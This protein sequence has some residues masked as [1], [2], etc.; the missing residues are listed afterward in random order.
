MNI[1]SIENLSKQYNEKPLFKNINIG[2]SQGEKIGLVGVNGAGKSTFIKVITGEVAPES[3][4][5]AI[6][7][8]V[9]VGY[10]KQEPEFRAD[11][12]VWQAIFEHPNPV[13]EAVKKYEEALQTGEG[14]EEAMTAMTEFDAWNTEYKIKEILGK[15]G[16]HDTKAKVG[17]LSGGQKK[18]IALAQV[19]LMEPD[20]LILDEPTNHL[21]LNVIE[22][23]EQYLS[24]AN[25]SLLL[26]SHDRYFLDIVTDTIWEIDQ[27]QIFKYEGNYSYFLEARSERLS[28]QANEAEKARKMFNKELEWL[29][30]QPK[31][32]GTKAKYRI[33]AAEELRQ[34]S[35][36]TV[37][38]RKMEVSVKP[39]RQG[40]KVLELKE[41][42]KAFPDKK[43][44]TD[45]SYVFRRG[46]KIG[47][48]GDNGVG[49]S[50]FLN[51]ITGKIAPDKGIVDKGENTTFGYYTQQVI[52]MPEN[53]RVIDVVKEVAEFIELAN[54]EQVSASA[55]LTMFLFP[56]AKQYDLVAK[57]S[58]G[59]RRRLQLLR[60]LIKNPNFLILDEPTN[61]LD[62][63]TLTI[64][65]NFFSEFQ[66]CLLI[67]SH[68]RYFMDK[69]AEHL[70]IF[71]GNGEISDFNGSYSEYRLQKDLE[72]EQ[73]KVDKTKKEF[74]KKE[75]DK[76]AITT[77]NTLKNKGTDIKTKASFKEKQEFEALEKEIAALEHKK[78]E[79]V[80][81]LNGGGSHEEIAAWAKEIKN[82]DEAVEEKT[83]RWIEL[84]ELVM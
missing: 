77:A 25:L 68:D 82:I 5:V 20:F 66:G 8:G 83:L 57:L 81:K 1:I 45:F 6:R 28:N 54:G 48:V 23:L 3:G 18:R 46:E 4:T 67:V 37:E 47:I 55:L 60:V 73:K 19:L 63:F 26:V 36:N 41:V 35:L 14:L 42:F 75:N 29:R 12:T 15:L 74:D 50:T 38:D 58:G 33:N 64:L 16:I 69:L 34:K 2:I 78:N 10:L 24:T 22:W 27:E 7:N 44:I 52:Q 9:R 40:K 71:E 21:D 59:E 76:K 43:I 62:I 80:A 30:K 17:N 84:A 49:K 65:E 61:D 72:E 56:P 32:R 31:A 11:A 51:I 53:S 70:F 79:L 39:S 13:T